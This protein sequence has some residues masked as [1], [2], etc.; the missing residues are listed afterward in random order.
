MTS[1]LHAESPASNMPV[2]GEVLEI[3]EIPGTFNP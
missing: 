1:V 3:D 2:H